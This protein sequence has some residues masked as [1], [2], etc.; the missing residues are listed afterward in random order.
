MT[1]IGQQDEIKEFR[2]RYPIVSAILFICFFLLLARMWY[3][4]ILKG[5]EHYE[6]SNQQSLR[7]EKIPA[8]RGIIFDRYG[9]PLI[10][11]IPA[12]DI[13]LIPQFIKDKEKVSGEVA[14]LLDLEEA[15]ILEALH[16]AKNEPPF[17]PVIIKANAS[18]D[19]IARAEANLLEIPALEIQVGIKRMYLYREI[20]SHVLGTLGQ[21]NE[22]E[23]Q[24]FK[25]K[26][27]TKYDQFSLLGKTGLEKQWEKILSGTDGAAF[28]AVDARGFR[29]QEHEK[30]IFGFLASKE[31]QPGN[32]LILTIDQDLQNAAYEALK[33]QVGSVVAL[34]PQTGEVLAMTSTPSFDPTIFS[35]GISSEDWN[36]LVNNPYKP[37]KN[38]AIQDHY[39]PGSTYKAITAISGLE[40]QKINSTVKYSCPGLFS[41]MRGLYRCWQK[42]GHGLVEIHKALRES[43]DVYF[44]NVGVNTGIDRLAHFG[45]EF[46]LGQRTGIL[47]DHEQPGLAPTKGWREKRFGSPW[48]PGETVSNAIGQGFNL[49][50]TLQLANLYATIGNGGKL[51]RPYLVSRIEDAQGAPLSEFQ[52]ELIHTVQVSKNTLDLVK[53][54]LWEVVNKPGGTAYGRARIPGLDVAGKTGTAQVIRQAEAE[55]EKKCHEVEYKFR[56]HALFAAYAPKDQAEIAVGVIVEH[57][58]HGSATAAPIAK[59]VIEAYFYKKKILLE[60]SKKQIETPEMETH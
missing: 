60:K 13:T 28:V 58:C 23:L 14:K 3:L 36:E 29:R 55:R 49:V 59:A 21:I 24:T 41:Y 27:A 53:E 7:Q 39:P 51:Y 4:Q 17:Q 46:G 43:C 38:K 31:A 12:F 9:V 22:S 33:N 50:T 8:P 10:D 37:L 25:V 32:N 56:D 26:G 1:M 5:K 52:P 18:R 48:I 2:Y 40:D 11:N 19:E 15:S 6:F 42:E 45:R 34:N 35:R 16:K 20:G 57:G 44:Y 47:L 30:N 54:G